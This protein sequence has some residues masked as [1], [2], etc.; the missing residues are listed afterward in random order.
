MTRPLRID[1]PFCLYHVMSRT[2]SGDTAFVKRSDKNRFLHY[3]RKYI[4]LFEFKLHVFCLMDNH[5]HLLLESGQRPDLSEF[6][7]RLLTAYTVYYNKK[8]H[9]HGHLFQGR[10][11][12]FVVDKAEYLITLSRYIH[13][14]PHVDDIEDTINYFGSSL[15]YYIH[16]NEPDFLHTEEIL[17]WFERDRKKY[18]K[19][20]REG[21][22][23][24]DL[25]EI[26]KQRFV[27]GQ[28][29]SNRMTDRMELDKAAPGM[30][31]H[32]ER[33]RE[34]CREKDESRAEEILQEVADYYDISP[35]IIKTG[36]RAK[37]DIGRARAVL[38]ALM[39][40]LLPW[41]ARQIGN[42][43]GVNRSI[44]R[45]ITRV[46]EDK[47]LEKDYQRILKVIK[48]RV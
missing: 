30:S 46:N 41:T 22:E 43:I 1:L 44:Y 5:F 4:K 3:L 25:V 40:S 9:R 29:F 19:Y 35:L 36:Y 42:W 37:G 38:I 47:E 24:G 21:L 2:N 13:L 18:E 48:D 8:H 12:S 27:G 28:A 20:I 16:G 15:L 32:T 10:F 14:N 6:M 39:R 31:S 17:A 7:R 33:V 34:H 26:Y 45:Y 23:E 11:K